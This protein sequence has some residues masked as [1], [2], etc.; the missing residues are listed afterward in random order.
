MQLW[1]RGK[2]SC[3][4]SILDVSGVTPES[5]NWLCGGIQ[6]RIPGMHSCYSILGISVP[7]CVGVILLHVVTK[8]ICGVEAGH[9][10][11]L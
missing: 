6:L 1:I 10:G 9:G 8:N 3:I 5:R 11:L 4:S 7:D 2:R